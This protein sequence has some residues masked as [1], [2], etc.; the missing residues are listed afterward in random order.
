[1]YFG[2]LFTVGATETKDF[3]A[4]SLIKGKLQISVNQGDKYRIFKQTVQTTA[5]LNDG[6]FHHVEI[7]KR[8]KVLYLKKLFE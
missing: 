1:M 6:V 7:Y 8:G 5:A 2:F 3:V 4:V